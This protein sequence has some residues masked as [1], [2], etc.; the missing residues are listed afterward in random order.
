MV[1]GDPVAGGARFALGNHPY[2]D[3]V[4]QRRPEVLVTS[5]R[6]ADEIVFLG[7]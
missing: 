4:A 3:E 7:P 5:G 2:L 6:Y 1:Q